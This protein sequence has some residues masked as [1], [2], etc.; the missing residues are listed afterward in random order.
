[1]DW[2]A[3]EDVGDGPA[4]R[5]FLVWGDVGEQKRN[6]RRSLISAF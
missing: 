3:I 2:L 4:Q 6:P 5:L 1:L